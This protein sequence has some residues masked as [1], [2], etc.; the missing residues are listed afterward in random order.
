MQHVLF[1]RSCL[2]GIPS[3]PLPFFVVIVVFMVTTFRV[4]LPVLM[5]I[6]RAIPLSTF[7][8]V[9]PDEDL[10]EA[11]STLDNKIK[12]SPYSF[13]LSS[14]STVNQEIEESVRPLCK[15]S[16]ISKVYCVPTMATINSKHRYLKAKQPCPSSKVLGLM[17]HKSKVDCVL[18][19]ATFNLKRCYPSDLVPAPRS[20]VQ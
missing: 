1:K 8:G 5:R 18:T 12:N 6:Y 9:L 7:I 19:T 3:H 13:L 11:N 16:H 15:Q 10:H 2:R 14:Y 4:L 17:S 20:L